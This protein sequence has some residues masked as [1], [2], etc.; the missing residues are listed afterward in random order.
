[1]IALLKKHTPGPLGVFPTKSPRQFT[2][3]RVRDSRCPPEMEWDDY[4]VEFSGYYGAH[5]PHVF[6]AAPE[7]LAA[8]KWAESALAPFSK[9]PAEKSGMS[10]IRAAIAK[11]EGRS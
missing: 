11:A 4:Y 10:L 2:I 5:G 7:M 8:L 3:T 1:M 9:E 6:A